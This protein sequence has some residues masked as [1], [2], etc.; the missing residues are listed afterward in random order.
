MIDLLLCF[1]F[2]RTSRSRQ[3]SLSHSLPISVFFSGSDM[4]S[5]ILPLFCALPLQSFTQHHALVPALDA[6]DQLWDPRHVP[7][8]PE[9]QFL[10]LL[11]GTL[12]SASLHFL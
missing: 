6:S 12:A 5:P 4:P 9:A 2:K 11:V 10:L 3:Y 8:P 7:E 1:Y